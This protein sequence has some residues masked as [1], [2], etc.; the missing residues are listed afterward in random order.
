MK[1]RTG[2]EFEGRDTVYKSMMSGRERD[3]REKKIY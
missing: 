2:S 1:Q 3:K